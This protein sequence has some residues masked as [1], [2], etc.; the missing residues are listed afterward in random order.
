MAASAGMG[1]AELEAAVVGV[2]MWRAGFGEQ[3][4]EYGHAAME[5]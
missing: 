3:N 4:V 5:V 2:Q 1:T